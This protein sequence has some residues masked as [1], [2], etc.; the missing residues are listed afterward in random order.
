MAA[1]MDTYG[2]ALT[3]DRAGFQKVERRA[4]EVQR[5]LADELAGRSGLVCGEGAGPRLRRAVTAFYERQGYDAEVTVAATAGG[6]GPYAA[7][8]LYAAQ[9]LEVGSFVTV[10]SCR[11]VGDE[12]TVEVGLMRR[13]HGAI[14]RNRPVARADA[15]IL[16]S[17]HHPD[18]IARWRR[19]HLSSQTFNTI[20]DML[21]R[22][23]RR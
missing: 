11:R 14:D 8:D 16:Y 5:A 20:H 3:P 4:G 1:V 21:K 12:P 23:S 2:L 17:A 13:L 6:T 18:R 7:A 15:T 22:I 19:I 9:R 10:V